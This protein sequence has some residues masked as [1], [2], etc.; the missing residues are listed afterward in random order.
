MLFIKIFMAR[1]HF[2]DDNMKYTPVCPERSKRFKSCSCFLSI[3]WFVGNAVLF[4]LS[5]TSVSLVWNDVALVLFLSMS[6][7]I[8]AILRRGYTATHQ[9]YYKDDASYDGQTQN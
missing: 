1:L 3:N 4:V 2:G 9:Q 6:V 7:K 8:S 5:T